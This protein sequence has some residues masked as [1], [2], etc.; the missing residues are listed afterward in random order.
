MDGLLAR[1]NDPFVS[2]RPH[3]LAR[4][5]FKERPPVMLTKTEKTCAF[6]KI[7]RSESDHLSIS[8]SLYQQTNW[9]TGCQAGGPSG[10]SFNRFILW[11]RAKLILQVQKGHQ[12]SNQ[13]WWFCSAATVQQSSD[14]WSVVK[15]WK[16]KSTMVTG[17][18]RCD[19][20]LCEPVESAEGLGD[21]VEES[22][23]GVSPVLPVGDSML[24]EGETLRC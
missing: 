8:C 17:G 13:S 22:S 12:C 14:Q 19:G 16:S 4:T 11:F 1:K 6:Y 21:E 7:Y 10:P 18:C 15:S 2:G 5:H 23:A 24:W 9:R 3:T 20:S